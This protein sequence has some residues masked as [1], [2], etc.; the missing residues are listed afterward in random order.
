MVKLIVSIADLWLNGSADALKSL[1]IRVVG[2]EPVSNP[3]RR[4][5]GSAES[6]AEV[7]A[8][9]KFNGTASEAPT[10]VATGG[11][12]GAGAGGGAG[13]GAGGGAG[14]SVSDGPGVV[15]GSC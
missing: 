14:T 11:A 13:A 9:K 6:G 10:N 8:S 4:M 5:L 3:I 15:A 2:S 1:A 7:S 12:A